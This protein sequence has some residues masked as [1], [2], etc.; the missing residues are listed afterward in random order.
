MRPGKL[1]TSKLRVPAKSKAF[2]PELIRTSMGEVTLRGHIKS[3]TKSW[4]SIYKAWWELAIAVDFVGLKPVVGRI[5]VD[6]PVMKQLLEVDEHSKEIET[7]LQR[8]RDLHQFEVSF[9]KHAQDPERRDKANEQLANIRKEKASLGKD[10]NR[11]TKARSSGKSIEGMEIRLKVIGSG[12]MPIRKESR[13]RKAKQ[14]AIP[15]P[16]AAAA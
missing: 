14:K 7:Q 4:A 11:L 13:K 3:V 9:K 1:D 5:R 16:D 10:I 2:I 8:V 6:W 15:F 12:K